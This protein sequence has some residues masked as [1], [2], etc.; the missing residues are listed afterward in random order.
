MKKFW[1]Y[2]VGT[3]DFIY[4]LIK[5]S[6]Q[7]Y[8][9]SSYINFIINDLFSDIFHPENISNS[10]YYVIEK[11]FESEINKLTNINDFQKVIT[12]SNT[13]YILGG[14]LFKENIQSYFSLVLTDI[15]EGYENSEESSRPIIFKIKDIEE[16]L[17]KEE[18]KF[19]KELKRSDTDEKR[20]ELIKRQKKENYLFHQLYKMNLPK[21]T[22]TMTFCSTL[23][24]TKYE[25]V[26][27][28]NKKEND[29]FIRKY[30][31]DLKKKDLVDLIS[32]EKN[33][34]VKKYLQQKVKKCSNDIYLFSNQT[35]MNN[36]Q[37]SSKSEKTLFF[38]QKSFIISINLINQILNKFSVTLDAIPN[39][40]K[41][42][43]KIIYDLLKK[44]FNNA[45]NI[46]IYKQVGCFFFMKLFKYIFLSPD[47][48]PLINNVILS[49]STKKNIFKIFEIFS[50]LISGEFFKSNEETSDY[51]PFNWYFI[52]KIN[53]IYDFCKKL[54][55]VQSPFQKKTMPKDI[56]DYFLTYS[57]CYNF[58]IYETTINIIKQNRNILFENKKHQKLEELIDN[59]SKNF[60]AN[61]PKEK[62]IINF[63]LYFEII[64]S[65]TYKDIMHETL[66]NK[67]FKI[68]ESTMKNMPFQHKNSGSLKKKDEKD[69][70]NLIK[71]KNLLSDILI[72]IDES[73]INE[74]N[75][76]IKNSS[77]KDI[78]KSLK[79][80][81]N[82]KSISETNNKIQINKDLN[83]KNT[84]IEWYIN[85]LLICLDKLSDYDSKND[86]YNLFTSFTKDIKNSIRHYNFKLLSQIIDKLKYT[87]Y[88]IKYI[89]TFQKKYVELII[90]SKIK[91][92]IEKE[93]INVIIKLIY[94]LKE[95][96]LSIYIPE[97]GK[98]SESSKNKIDICKN[99]NDFISKFPN[100]T[101]IEKNIDPELFEIEG[102]INLKGALNDYL[103]ILKSKMNKYFKENE[104]NIAFYKLK[105]YILSKI[106]EKIYPQDYDND[107]LLYYYKAISLSWVEPRHLKIPNDINVDNFIPITNSFF[108]QIDHERSPSCKMEVI[109]KIFNTINSAIRF[110]HGGNFSTDDI[111]P[112]FEYAL[113]K[114]RPERLSSNLRFIEYFITKGS[115]LNNMYFDFLKDNINNLKIINYTQ[116]DG[117]TEEEFK[118]KCYESNK[119]YMS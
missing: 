89:K 3:P 52:D 12:D 86:Y 100:L 63:F 66:E 87:K 53:I 55:S 13:G 37:K 111:A 49:E 59:L 50:Q 103:E 70:K 95:K 34:N 94:N 109:A 73:E 77:T 11:L 28:K 92:F 26:I 102:N 68:T 117:I 104:K 22:N 29:L 65:E 23:T 45:D 110:S 47:Y 105:K 83:K 31:P 5:N 106:Y 61:K 21:N 44:K 79:D 54:V 114:A 118:Q 14:L 17:K 6:N 80:Y 119:A 57:V 9:T 4:E 108:N 69:E 78:L 62:N 1:K 116:F 58:E 46:D 84:P 16:H 91:S 67:N 30:I 101:K 81:Y 10:L 20:R 35:L 19:H 97:N 33:D 41:Y 40:I 72:A 48:Y 90:N 39:S 74:I 85:S 42:I 98:E 75:H 93:K 43:S 56:K 107:D 32:K 60:E 96:I 25:E 112:I 64:F 113:I 36:I 38:Y 24:L 99:I 71:A 15:I 76:R 2:L 8:L 18:E 115:E 27:E 88:S 82:S 51:T 7:E